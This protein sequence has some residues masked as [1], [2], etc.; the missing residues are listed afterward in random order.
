VWTNPIGTIIESIGGRMTPRDFCFW[1]KGILDRA[2]SIVFQ[3][4]QKMMHTEV[5]AV[6]I[7][8]SDKNTDG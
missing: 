3:D 8:L 6:C 7:N 1:L 4:I 2:D 5:T